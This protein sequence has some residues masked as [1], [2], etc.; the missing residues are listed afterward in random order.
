MH[1]VA[2]KRSFGT[3]LIVSTASESQPRR[4]RDAAPGERLDMIELQEMATLASPS[5]GTDKG[6]PSR[7]ALP[8]GTTNVSGDVASRPLLAPSWRR[9]WIKGLNI[10]SPGN[11]KLPP[12]QPGDQGIQRAIQKLGHVP[13]WNGMAEQCLGV[14][15]LVMGVAPDR[16]TN[17][18]P[19]RHC[20]L[21][22][23]KLSTHARNLRWR[24]FDAHACNLRWR[25]L[26]ARS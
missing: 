19:F 20:N 7:V 16:D 1:E 3:V 23:R 2:A 4:S 25:K 13:G 6:A 9:R 21:R 5:I 17:E 26:S 24:K 10:R 22:W 18:I 14:A 11:T 8:H 15:Q 12:L